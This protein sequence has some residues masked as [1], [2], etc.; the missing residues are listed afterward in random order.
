MQALLD[1]YKNQPVSEDETNVHEWLERFAEEIAI[2]C[3]KL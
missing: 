3:A 2:A 1:R